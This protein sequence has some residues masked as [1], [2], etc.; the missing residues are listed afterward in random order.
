MVNPMVSYSV[1]SEGFWYEAMFLGCK[2]IF[3]RKMKVDGI[4]EMFK[5]RLVIQGFKQKSGIDYFDTY[6][7]IACI[8]TIRL[9]IALALIHNLII[10]QMD[11][12]TTFLNGELDEKVYMNQPQGFIMSGNENKAAILDMDQVHGDLTKEFLSSRLSMKDMGGKI[13]IV[14]SDPADLFKRDP[15][16]VCMGSGLLITKSRFCEIKSPKILCNLPRFSLDM[17]RL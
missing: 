11:E 14:H 4:I 5:A 7:L 9:M 16:S 1:L 8:S 17:A 12:K 3:I 6:A 13:G 15:A 10:H 2:W